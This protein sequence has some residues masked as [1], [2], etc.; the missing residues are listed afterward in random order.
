MA[1]KEEIHLLEAVYKLDP[2]TGALVPS[3]KDT[4]DSVIGDLWN[5]VFGGFKAKPDVGGPTKAPSG[6]T[7]VGPSG[8]FKDYSKKVEK[9]TAAGG[10]VLEGPDRLDRVW[11]RKARGAGW[12][13]WSFP[14]GRVDKGESKEQAAVREV[15]EEIGV[16]ARI[17]P[18]KS[19]LGAY[20]GSFSTTH[21]YLMYATSGAGA[22]DDETEK[23]MLA[24]FS[25]AVHK[26]SKSGNTRDIKALNAAMDAVES[27]RTAAKRGG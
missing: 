18:G 19:Y 24:T 14:K 12:G 8:D 22:H 6:H 10:I 26:F 7:G 25:E 11:I 9:W 21:Y 5:R 2:K 20:D 16:R 17:F 27:M 1:L 15:Y 13:G 4:S 3:E 23:V